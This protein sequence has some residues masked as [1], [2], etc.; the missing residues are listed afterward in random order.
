[1][2]KIIVLYYFIWFLTYVWNTNIM[3]LPFFLYVFKRM[4]FLYVLRF[5]MMFHDFMTCAEWPPS[6]C[7]VTAEWVVFAY[8]TWICFCVFLSPPSDCRV[9]RRV[10]AEWLPGSWFSMTLIVFFISM[11]QK[12]TRCYS[13][14]TFLTTFYKSRCFCMKIMKTIKMLIK[15]KKVLYYVIRIICF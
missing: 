3:V 2:I 8:K 14:S 5:S 9:T 7:R 4:I 13:L 15:K 12:Q 6:D 10:T 1:M 11:Q